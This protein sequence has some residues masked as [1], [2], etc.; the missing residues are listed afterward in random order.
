MRIGFSYI[1]LS[2]S[3]SSGGTTSTASASI[4]AVPLTLSYLGVSSGNHFLEMGLGGT[5]VYASGSASGTGISASG[6]GLVPLGTVL[7]GYRRQP[8]DG[9]FQFRIGVEA[10]MGK[11]LALSSPDPAKFGVLPWIY[12]SLGFSL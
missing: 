10:L 5:A 3:A 8:P 12:M 6:S 7:L 9:G 4:V 11:G 1:G 2:A